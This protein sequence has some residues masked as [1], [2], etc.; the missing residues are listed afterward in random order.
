MKAIRGKIDQVDDAILAL[1]R[2]RNHLVVRIAAEKARDGHRLR[3]HNRETA[4]IA[5]LRAAAKTSGLNPAMVE[6]IFRL[7]MADSTAQQERAING[8]R[9]PP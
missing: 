6:K 2:R 7:I 9:R 3:D 5:R 8:R 1:L 4:I